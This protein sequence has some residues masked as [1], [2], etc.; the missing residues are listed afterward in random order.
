[1]NH[2]YR[3]A[4]SEESLRPHSVLTSIHSFIH[5]TCLSAYCVLG[6]FLGLGLRVMNKRMNSC[7]RA[8]YVLGD[9]REIDKKLEN[10]RGCQS[11]E[12]G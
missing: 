7:S 9:M 11:R 6:S 4:R 8:A 12:E 1:M 2:Y 10:P 3:V 5:Q